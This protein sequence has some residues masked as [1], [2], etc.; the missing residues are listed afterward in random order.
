[1]VERKVCEVGNDDEVDGRVE[2]AGFGFNFAEAGFKGKRGYAP[3]LLGGQKEFSASEPC[4]CPRLGGRLDSGVLR[5]L[6]GRGA[7]GKL[8]FQKA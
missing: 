2:G 3:E 1:M 4:S 6:C 8:R 7:G 5:A